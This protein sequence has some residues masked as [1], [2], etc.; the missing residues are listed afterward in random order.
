M[1]VASHI[2]IG[3]EKAGS[4]L[5]WWG[6]ACVTE[7]ALIAKLHTYSNLIL[8]MAGHRHVNLVTPFPSTDPD[9]PENGFWQIETSSLREFPQQFRTFEIVRNS[10]NNISIFTENID[11]LTE[12]D[13]LVAKSRSYAI[14][15]N[16]IY[17]ILK[18]VLPTGSLSYNAEL[19]KKLSTEMQTKISGCGTP[20][21]Q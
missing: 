3:V 14:A 7:E 17:K 4:L 6:N 5:G 18:P 10:D 16:Q 11:V 19:V 8:W 2:P 12:H 1:I 20:V 21:G 15:A 13:D 9:H